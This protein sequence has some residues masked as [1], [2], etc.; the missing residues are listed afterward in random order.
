VFGVT[1]AL[2]MGVKKGAAILAL[3]CARA[4]HLLSL[5]PMYI[6]ESNPDYLFL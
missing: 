4:N 2:Y 3:L 5:K 1:P 6:L